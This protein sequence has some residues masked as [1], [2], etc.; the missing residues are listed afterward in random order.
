V[1]MLSLL[2]QE[3][4]TPTPACNVEE[5]PMKKPVWNLSVSIVLLAWCFAQS[6]LDQILGRARSSSLS[7]DK[8]T[9]GLKE[10]LKV[11]TGNAV[12]ATGKPD[13][14]LKNAAIK[15]LLPPK[16]QTVGKGMRVM[17]MGQQ[18]DELEVGMNRAA[19]QATPAAKQIFLN[20]LTK[21]TFSDA[22]AILSGTDTAATDFFKRTSTDQLTTAFTPIVHK[23]MENV[24]V[25]KQYDEL[26]QNPM[27]ARLNA[28]GKLDLD[29]YVVGKA[30][31]GIF[32]MM[33]QEEKKIR[34][35]PA[36]QITPLLKEVF[37][38]K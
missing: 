30:L 31:D 11:S 32:Y 20:S 1:I 18:A 27:A 26:L 29:K 6:P 38:K 21:M 8:I 14:F 23:S 37:G 12:A 36:A 10:A 16:L 15:I 28:G 4:R 25:V 3:A 2:A 35:D 17:G 7:N 33:G 34:K 13:G 19:E 22:R 9:A 5:P 24:G